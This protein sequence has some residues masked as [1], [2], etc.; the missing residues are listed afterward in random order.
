VERENTDQRMEVLIKIMSSQLSSTG[1]SRSCIIHE[2]IC[3]SEWS[4]CI[5]SFPGQFWCHDSL[6]AEKQVYVGH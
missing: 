1:F 2:P 3:F 4:F 5:E 6:E